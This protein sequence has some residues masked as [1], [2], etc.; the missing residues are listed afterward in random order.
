M[1]EGC[2][3]SEGKI[4]YTVAAQTDV[5]LVRKNNEDNLLVADLTTS[6]PLNGNVQKSYALAD[7]RLLLIVSDGM[8]GAQAGEIASEMTVLSIKDSLDKL[9]RGIPAHDRLIAAVEEAN[10]MVWNEARNNEQL[11]GM[12]A[13]VTA[14]LIEGKEAYIAEVG[15]SRAYLIRRNQVKQVT[16]DQ[17]FVAQLIARGLLKPEDAGR[18][19]RKNVILQSIGVRETIQVAVSMFEL[20]RGDALLLCSD[21]LSNN[22]SL[23]EILQ[24]S[25]NISLEAG[26]KNLIE[27]AKVRG[28]QDNITA[29]LSR[30]DG[31]ALEIPSD[32]RLSSGLL[33]TISEFNPDKEAAKT[34]KRT[35][36][37]GNSSLSNIFYGDGSNTGAANLVSGLGNYPYSPTI[38]HECERLL[39]WVDYCHDF[40]QYK[41]QQLDAANSW[42]E[43]QGNFFVT[44]S[45][46]LDL[47]QNGLADLKKTRASIVELMQIFEKKN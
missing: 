32:T 24:E 38:T 28:G 27:L 44:R 22:V 40:L 18:H 12:G 13:T 30:F 2:A 16:T 17:S 6:Q 7:S 25:Q 14:A 39:E 8:G 19:P 9:P 11:H 21:G 29:I 41:V 36:L 1:P 3:M 20:K 46:A 15:D 23:N 5:G 45:Y 33:Q 31:E 43:S 37:L 34:H 35:E 47:I 4:Q 26:V 42:V 10:N